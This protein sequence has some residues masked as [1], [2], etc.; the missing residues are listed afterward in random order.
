MISKDLE[1][2]EEIGDWL[3]ILRE[4]RA[5]KTLKPYLLKTDQLP[6]EEWARLWIHRCSWD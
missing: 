5:Q 3:K 6:D 4:G 1:M 2:R